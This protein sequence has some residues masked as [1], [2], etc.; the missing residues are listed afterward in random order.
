MHRSGTSALTGA[1]GRLGVELGK[2]LMPS[3]E[4]N[5]KGYWENQAVYEL[6]ERLLKCLGTRWHSTAPIPAGAWETPAIRELMVEA[7]EIVERDFGPAPLL[8]MKD[9][10]FSRLMP[11]WQQVLETDGRELAFVIALR[12]PISVARSLERRDEIPRTSAYLLWLVYV[13]T[14][15]SQTRGYRRIV[16]DYDHLLESPASEMLRVARSLGL[17]TDFSVEQLRMDLGEQLVPE[18]RHSAYRESVLEL[19]T[20]ACANVRLAYQ[21][22]RRLARD[23]VSFEDSG[24]IEDWERIA[25]DLER[26]TPYLRLLDSM[27]DRVPSE[28]RVERD[29]ALDRQRELEVALEGVRESAAQESQGLR[30]TISAQE[31]MLDKVEQE[32]VALR[33]ELATR[34]AQIGAA[35]SERDLLKGQLEQQRDEQERLL[36]QHRDE[37]ERLL[38]Q[39]RDEREGLL[40]TLSQTRADLARESAEAA[41]AAHE[42]AERTEALRRIDEEARLWA[43]AVHEKA[44]EVQALES[45]VFELQSELDESRSQLIA[46]RAEAE[47]ATVQLR[48][49]A[50]QAE[51]VARERDLFRQEL[52]RIHIRLVRDLREVMTRFPRARATMKK[53]AEVSWAWLQQRRITRA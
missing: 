22:L 9:P 30:Q 20:A 21:W 16:V 19:D 5:V 53:A 50:A 47:Q 44:T 28:L 7:A 48:A 2:N 36:E 52:D 24:F 4:D 18:L 13:V 15:V 14:A 46:S 35:L 26:M 45:R 12:N 39:H 17:P 6:N 33:N 37:R 11:F 29:V 38:E 27:R 43:R 8:G 34:D 1:L 42:L 49:L 10:R 51:H 41:K 31:A 23:E 32:V 25:Q 3:T 40:G